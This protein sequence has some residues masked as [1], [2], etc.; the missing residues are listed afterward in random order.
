[1]ALVLLKYSDMSPSKKR[2]PPKVK[3]TRARE[4]PASVEHLDSVRDELVDRIGAVQYSIKAVEKR[5]DARFAASD[6][7]WDARLAEM[8][9]KWAASHAAMD[10]KWDARLAEMDAKWTATLAAMD[11]KW[12]ARLAAMDV[13][14]EARLAEMDAK[15]DARFA[16]M[17]AK[18]EA[19]FL[20]IESDILEIKVM[21]TKQD[22]K[23]DRM[24]ALFEE[25][26]Y[27]NKVSTEQFVSFEARLD[28]LELE[29]KPS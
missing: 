21:L 8:D 4:W 28:R 2:K 22:A 5:I 7:K 14:W 9:V 16:E 29:I 26:N 25:Q 15:W 17:N 3:T 18:F 27:R 13:K 24:L 10:A 12:E 11:A 1:M 23:L 19:R 6:A 20:K